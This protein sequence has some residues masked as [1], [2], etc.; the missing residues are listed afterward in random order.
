VSLTHVT[1]R[2]NRVRVHEYPNKRTSSVGGAVFL[3][4]D[5]KFV[6]KNPVVIER[7]TFVGNEAQG[8]DH[9]DPAHE[10]DFAGGGL[11]IRAETRMKLRC[12]SLEFRGNK[13]PRGY[14]CALPPPADCEG[15]DGTWNSLGTYED[16]LYSEGSASPIPVYLI[17]SLLVAKRVARPSLAI[18]DSHALPPDCSN[19]RPP[20]SKVK[21]VVIHFI[22]AA[23]V[24]PEDP[25]NLN[26]ILDIL[27]GRVPPGSPKLSAHYL[28][29]RSGKIHR[30]VGEGRRAWH[31]GRSRMPTGE[32][33][34]NDFSI[35]VEMVRKAE[36]VPTDAQYESL[37]QLI[38][39]IKER[40]SDLPLE[41]IIGHD[42]IRTLWNVHHPDRRA[43][44]KEDPGPLFHWPTL[45]KR[46]NELGFGAPR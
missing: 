46:L 25:H 12:R 40:H 43:P 18:D 14:H 31:A 1:F 2:D 6:F 5:G 3:H 44:P 32:E 27:A 42:T 39:D 35:G 13:A 29:D 9:A 23:E 28:I 15:W 30:L 24:A 16:P 21:A 22:S 10:H 36:E 41:G 20:G 17:P 33:D 37:A 34:V 4:H 11:Y 26:K 19:A 38:M 7:C 8:T 45:L